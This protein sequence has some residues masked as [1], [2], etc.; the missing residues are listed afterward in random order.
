MWNS[1]DFY[2]QKQTQYESTSL[3]YFHK[4]EL[5]EIPCVDQYL[6]TLTMSVNKIMYM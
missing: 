3:I 5:L 2:G 6:A 4:V 1:N